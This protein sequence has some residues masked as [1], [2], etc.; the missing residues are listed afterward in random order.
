VVPMTS[1]SSAMRLAGSFPVVPTSTN[2]LDLE[3]YALTQQLRAIDRKR[4]QD[5][6]GV[7]GDSDLATLEAEMRSLL[8]L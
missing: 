7:L 6:I 3:S 4:I 8:R 1:Q 2:G 5:V